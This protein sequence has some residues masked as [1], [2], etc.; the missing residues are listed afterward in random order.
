MMPLGFS[1]QEMILFNHILIYN[2]LQPLKITCTNIMTC[3]I[4][5]FGVESY[6]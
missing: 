2:H 5:G 6:E 3:I 1:V 4:N